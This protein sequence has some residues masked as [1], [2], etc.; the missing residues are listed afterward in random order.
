V[1]DPDFVADRPNAVAWL[2]ELESKLPNTVLFFRPW[3]PELFERYALFRNH[4]T[5]FIDSVAKVPRASQVQIDLTR[6]LN[7][8]Y[9]TGSGF[10]IPLALYLGFRQIYLVGFD[11][12]WLADIH[13]GALHFYKTNPHF[14]HFDHTATEG[15]SMEEQLRTMHL[16][17]RSHRFLREIA[18]RRGQSIRNAT[19]DGWLDMYE[20]VDYDSLF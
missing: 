17:F 2:R 18:G 6:P 1:G 8:G 4:Q 13:R 12:N 11:A 16:E 19:I 9:T 14:P 3:A 10:A 15:H 5:H 20:R 7:V